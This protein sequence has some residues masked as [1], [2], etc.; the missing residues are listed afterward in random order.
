MNNDLPHVLIDLARV[1][2][3]KVLLWD[4][5]QWRFDKALSDQL[6]NTS[7][8]TVTPLGHNLFFEVAI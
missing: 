2:D 7:I 4:G 6:D 3:E 1:K 8:R 5:F